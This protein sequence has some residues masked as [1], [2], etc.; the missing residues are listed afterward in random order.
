[1]G[2][3]HADRPHAVTWIENKGILTQT[4]GFLGPGYTHT[5]N[6]YLGCAFS[7][8]LCGT[9][10]Y[11][12]HNL[13]ITRGRPWA[14]YG[15]KRHTREPYR[16]EYDRLK[17]PRRGQ[18]RPLRIYMSSSTDPY[19]PP[20]ARLGLT[21]GLLEEMRERPPDVLVIQSHNT[22]IRR[23][24]ELILE[25][26]HRCELWVSL[27]VETNMDPVPGFPP[28]ASRPARRLEVLKGFRERGVRTQATVS[29]LLPIADP[30]AFAR[31]LDEACDRVILDHYLIGDGSP[32]G[33]RTKRTRFVDRLVEAGFSEWAELG[34]LWEVRDVMAAVLGPGRV[35]VSQD[36]FNAVGQTCGTQAQ[37]GS[38]ASTEL[39]QVG[40]LRRG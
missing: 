37:G 23:D 36:G 11:A 32:G 33:L 1:M 3:V 13:W 18:P 20:E 5:V 6:A 34:K 25:L 14:L 16:A 4:S 27:T 19:V 31:K 17:R 30:K 9:F 21:R 39:L 8:A 29:P 28:H 10:C 35:L 2:E 15:A 38:A 40:V 7:G 26:S 12:M 22:L 24:F